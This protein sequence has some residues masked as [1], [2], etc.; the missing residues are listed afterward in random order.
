M[1]IDKKLICYKEDRQEVCHIKTE[2]NFLVITSDNPIDKLEKRIAY[3][4]ED[5][6][7]HA[8][9][10]EVYKKMGEGFIELGDLESKILGD[11]VFGARAPHKFFS[12]V[13]DYNHQRNLIAV[14]VSDH[15]LGKPFVYLISILDGSMKRIETRFVDRLL[16]SP[17]GTK[18]IMFT[19]GMPFEIKC[20]DL[21]SKEITLVEKAQ[22]YPY[23][24][25]YSCLDFTPDGFLMCLVNKEITFIDLKDY[26]K[27]QTLLVPEID[28]SL[29][30]KGMQLSKD[31]T[32]VILT[33]GSHLENET[34]PLI[35]IY[36]RKEGKWLPVIKSQFKEV[37]EAVI[38]AEIEKA[39]LAPDLKTLWIVDGHGRG[40]YVIDR[41]TYRNKHVF[42]LEKEEGH[43][44]L[45]TCKDLYFSQDGAWAAIAGHRQVFVYEVKTK[46]LLYKTKMDTPVSKV[47]LSYDKKY[48]IYGGSS[49]EIFVR[50]LISLQE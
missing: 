43:F 48:L 45:Q 35:Q 41:E 5:K 3:E 24:G 14:A 1:K 25:L 40:P 33:A 10:L 31:G 4:D 39:Y 37:I 22:A 32:Q 36:D 18:L 49:G 29:S 38:K 23:Y 8:L 17:D 30:Y 46:K 42:I 16:F 28:N 9:H 21:D 19:R 11:I 26:S 2:E 6:A 34:L 15:K 50:S 13:I 27:V 20:Y 12:E 44:D 47:L 7:E